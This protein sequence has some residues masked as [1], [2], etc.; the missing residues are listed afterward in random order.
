MAAK[1]FASFGNSGDTIASLP[2]LRQYY[3]TTGIKPIL[4]LVKDHPAEYYEGATHPVKNDK[5]EQV[6]LNQSMCEML[7]PLFK[8]Q[9]YL[10]DVITISADQYLDANINVNLSDIRNTFCN[11]PQG[12]LRRWVFYVF[13]DL[14]CNLSEQYLFVPDLDK[15]IAK[16]KVVISRSERYHN[17]WVDYSWL[18]KYED[19][20]I[21]IGTQR[22]YNNFCMNYGLYIKKVNVTDFLQYAQILK[23]A[24]F[25][26]SNQTMAFQ[27]SQGLKIPRIVELCH[28]AANVFPDGEDAYDFYSNVAFQYYFDKLY[29]K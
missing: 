25:H 27:I 28:W 19:D 6:S 18:K 10:E 20:C 23:Q 3:R 4:Y 12:D 14:A 9:D 17:E 1:T 22:E 21:F 11:I 8:L 13:P 29:N 5:G 16:G 7:T 26:L 2:A 24:K 15:D